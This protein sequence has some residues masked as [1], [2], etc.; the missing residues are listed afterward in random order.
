[1]KIPGGLRLITAVFWGFALTLAGCTTAGEPWQN[2]TWEWVQAARISD[3]TVFDVQDP[4]NYT[5]VFRPDG[6]FSGTADCNV[7][8]GTY[9][10]NP[11]GS[12]I[13]R[14]GPATLAF[15]GEGSVD[16]EYLLMLGEIDTRKFNEAGSLFLESEVGGV[17][18]EFRNGGRAPRE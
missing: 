12:F 3:S 4:G 9:E 7:M 8:G 16:V 14:P 18:M 2:I 5:I 10:W 15:C 1:V 6:T 17:Q 13:I 11:Q